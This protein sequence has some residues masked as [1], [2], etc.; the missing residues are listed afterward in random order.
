MTVLS[1]ARIIGTGSYI[2]KKVLSNADLE[3]M[4]ET[5]DEWIVTRTGMKERR[6]AGDDE[7]SSTMGSEAALKAL[8]QASIDPKDVDLILCATLTPDYMFPSTACII[9]KIIGCDNASAMDIQAACTGYLYALS[10]AK[11]YID[12]GM[13]TNI[14]IIASEKLSSVVNYEDR[15]TCVLFGDGASACVVSNKGKGLVINNINLGADGNQTALLMMPG[16]GCRH[17]ASLCTIENKM[18]FIQMDGKETFKHAVRRMEHAAKE[19]IDQV[20]L[21]NNAIS[22]LIPHQANIRII[23]AIA[24]RFD[25]PMEKVF[26]TI[27]KYGNTSASSIGIAL[28]ELLIEKTIQKGDNLLLIAFGAGLTWGACILTMEDN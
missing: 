18:H 10:M 24:K 16:G 19:C 5:S 28:D 20:G 15:N 23:E 13:Y 2:P 21:S 27:H 9:Q 26:L 1:K 8:K 11:A 25:V 22:W 12:S 17:P 7:F 14:L 4:V 3:K 6:I